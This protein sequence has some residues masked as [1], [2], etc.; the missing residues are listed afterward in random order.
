MSLVS[1]AMACDEEDETRIEDRG[2]SIGSSVD[3]VSSHH[4]SPG[5]DVSESGD[6]GAE[7]LR[8]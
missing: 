6:T 1:A 2:S 4:L 8:G 5:E 3:V 7:L